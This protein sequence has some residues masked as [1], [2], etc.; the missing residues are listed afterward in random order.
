MGVSFEQEALQS[1]KFGFCAIVWGSV[2]LENGGKKK[3]ILA[4]TIHSR[5]FMTETK[6]VQACISHLITHGNL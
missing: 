3:V 2:E 4:R 6:Y 1:G 5:V